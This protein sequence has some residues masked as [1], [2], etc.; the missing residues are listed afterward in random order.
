MSGHSMRPCAFGVSGLRGTVCALTCKGFPARCGSSICFLLNGNK[1]TNRLAGRAASRGFDFM[2]RPKKPS[3][4]KRP[5]QRGR[6]HDDA[7][8]AAVIAALLAGQ[9][10]NDVARAFGLAP[11]VISDIKGSV[12][13]EKFEQVRIEKKE[14]LVDLIEG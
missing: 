4:K 10:V 2:G 13:G 11:S 6:Q 7:T 8:R 1:S 5:P 3:A 12:P 14:R 9:P